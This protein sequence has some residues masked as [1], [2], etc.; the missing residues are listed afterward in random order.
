MPTLEGEGMASSAITLRPFTNVTQQHVDGGT[1]SPSAGL[2]LHQMYLMGTI[3]AI[4]GNILISISL[5]IQ[6]KN[7]EPDEEKKYGQ[8]L[9]DNI[10]NNEEVVLVIL[11]KI[12]VD[13]SPDPDKI[14]PRTLREKYTHVRLLY[15]ASLTP[16][17]KS[18]LWW[19]GIFLMGLASAA[20]SVV[21]LKEKLRSSY[22]LGGS[23]AVLGT[24]L[25]VT[26]AIY[27]QQ[28]ITATKIQNYI[29]SWEFLLY[30]TL[31]FLLFCVLLY[32]NKR[33]GLNHI[34]IL[35]LMSSLLASLTVI[36]V[37]AVAGMVTTS[38]EGHLQ[39]QYPIFYLMVVVM[40]VSCAFQ[41]QFL[42]QAMRLYKATEVVPINFVF[43]TTS[44]IIA[45]VIFYQEFYGAALLNVFM[46]LLG[47]ML[48]F[49]GVFLIAKNR[50][51]QTAEVSYIDMGIIPSFRSR[52]DRVPRA[53]GGSG[54][55]KL[56]ER[57]RASCSRHER[58]LG[59]EVSVMAMASIFLSRKSQE[60]SN[61]RSTMSILMELYGLKNRTMIQWV[62]MQKNYQIEWM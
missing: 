47:C 8:E 18:K 27:G 28:E 7:I 32:L 19:C 60:K 26:F 55:L 49:L 10:R 16:Y 35:L 43:F 5:N 53:P 36:S 51:K 23:L 25:L 48:S 14:F 20:I 41:V 9:M 29:V 62:K 21:F 52:N 40:V 3:L 30:M 13:K 57:T 44:A 42:N 22:I 45:G 4:T 46:F 61:H 50:E 39:L 15:R 34:V 56:Q 12:K 6:E 2:H 31:E 38:I 59:G 11:K 33:R 54:D 17:Y 1:A 24:Y 58:G 37:K